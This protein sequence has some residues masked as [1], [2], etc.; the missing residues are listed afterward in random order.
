MITYG[1]DNVGRNG[2]A[3]ATDCGSPVTGAWVG[4]ADKP[5]L[6]LRFMGLVAGA[7]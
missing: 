5:A 1:Y 3:E 7:G 4:G 6:V 2:G